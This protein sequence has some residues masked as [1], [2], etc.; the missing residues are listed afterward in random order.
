[1]KSVDTESWLH[2]TLFLLF[3]LP[4]DMLETMLNCKI[5]KIL[6]HS[7]ILVPHQVTL[8]QKDNA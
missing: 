6:N 7:L 1:M 5:F 3:F 4:L 2:Q 8:K